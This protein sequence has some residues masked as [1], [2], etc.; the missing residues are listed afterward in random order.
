VARPPGDART[1]AVRWGLPDALL[2]YLGGFVGILVFTIAFSAEDA[3]AQ[4]AAYLAAA[5]AGQYGGTF[6]A[7]WLI[8]RRKGL[9]SVIDDFGLRLWVGDLWVLPAGAGLGAVLGV[10]VQPLSNL[11]GGDEQDVV[12]ELNEA[13][14]AKLVV[15]AVGAGLFAPVVE[16]LLFRGLLLRALL[17][18][19]PATPA[20]AVSSVVFALVHLVDPSLGTVVALPA[21]AA[22][23]VV[24][25][26][27]AV[28]SGALSR[29]IMLH[30]GFNLLTI[31][32]VALN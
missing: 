25:G 20:V 30:A 4:T 15:L 21:L 28:R 24:A 11:A 16:E 19:M 31:M 9:G 6:G 12:T 2:G 26:M 27:L 22:V 1:S 18:R 29:P 17:R 8:S 10:L 3:E 14:G 5:F 13:G 32:S 23:G 7:I